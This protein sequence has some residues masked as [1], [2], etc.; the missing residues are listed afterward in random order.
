[1]YLCRLRQYRT[2]ISQWGCDK[3]VKPDEM[4]AIVRKRQQRRLVEDKG[5]LRFTVR[6]TPVEPQKI[7]RWMKRN[8]VSESFLYVP[9]PAA[10]KSISFVHISVTKL[11]SASHPIRCGLSDNLRNRISH[12]NSVV[13]SS[14]TIL[15]TRNT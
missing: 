1:V 6:G 2:R 11:T 15:I 9:S 12:G 5:D 4:K 14:I 10:C 8:E 7:Q 13:L 3:K